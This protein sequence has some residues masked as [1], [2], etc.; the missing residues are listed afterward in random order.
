M[1]QACELL[2]VAEVVRGRRKDATLSFQLAN[3]LIVLDV[4]PEYL[5]D[6]DSRGFATLLAW[7]NPEYTMTVNLEETEQAAAMEAPGDEAA[8]DHI[9]SPRVRVAA[10]QYLLRPIRGFEE[11]VT[12]VEFFV[13]SAREYRCQFGCFQSISRCS[14]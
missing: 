13:P 12:Q 3:D 7:L 9:L 4:V 6:P 11:F 8:R 2:H 14:C 1:W 5:D 10:F